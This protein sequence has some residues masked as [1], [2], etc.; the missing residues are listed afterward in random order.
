MSAGHSSSTCCTVS[1]GWVQLRHFDS[2]ASFNLFKCLLSVV[3]SVLSWKIVHCSLRGSL[4]MQS[5][6][7]GQYNVYPCQRTLENLWKN[8]RIIC[9]SLPHPPPTPTTP[10]PS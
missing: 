8:K 6:L 2:C 3:C 4:L 5:F 1:N 7:S 10:Y 9:S